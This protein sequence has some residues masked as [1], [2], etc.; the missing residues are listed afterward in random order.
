MK[1]DTIPPSIESAQIT[2]DHTIR[3]LYSEI[4]DQISASNPLHYNLG[5]IGYAFS[6]SGDPSDPKSFHVAFQNNIP[7]PFFDT[8]TVTGIRDPAGNE[9]EEI[10]I[11]VSRYKVKAF[12]VVIDEI[13]A[14][15]TPQVGL[16]DEEYVE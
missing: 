12:D 10:K 11:P 9:A 8:L 7:D 6:I 16:P 2:D 3:I 4:P 1:V 5:T 15:P 14:D 13:M